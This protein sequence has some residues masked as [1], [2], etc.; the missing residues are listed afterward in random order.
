[1]RVITHIILEKEK[2]EEIDSILKV[3]KTFFFVYALFFRVY[4][5]SCQLMQTI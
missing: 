5:R 1:M 2:E 4:S 3:L